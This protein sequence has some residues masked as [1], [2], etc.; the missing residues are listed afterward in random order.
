MKFTVHFK[1]PDALDY[2]LEDIAD[3]EEREKARD[4][5]SRWIQW[6]E[7]VSIEFDTEEQ[8]AKVR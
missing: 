7:S 4:F 1:T 6:G 3:E 8:T 5:A 2:A